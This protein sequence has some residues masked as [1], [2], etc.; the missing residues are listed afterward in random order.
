[1]KVRSNRIHAVEPDE[2]GYYER[3]YISLVARVYNKPYQWQWS[4]RNESAMKSPF[5]GMDP[6]LEAHWGDIHTSLMVYARNQLNTQLPDDLQA[7][8]EESL[9]VQEDDE[10]TRTV[11]ADVRVIEEPD[12]LLGD[13]GEATEVMTLAEPVLVTVIDEEQTQRQLEIV[14]SSDGG[15][16]VTAIEILSPANKLSADGQLAYI[17][18]QREY[19]DAR[20]NLI[21]IDLIRA[22]SFVLAVPEDRLPD[23]CRTNHLVCARR[24]GTPNVAELYPISLRRVLPNVR[25]P[26]RPKDQDV[27]LQLQP[28]LD[29]CYRDG[30]YDRL[31]Y[32]LDPTPRL[33]ESDAR[34]LDEVLRSKG[35]R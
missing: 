26:L 4:F 19:L 29:A 6:Y 21:E 18:K 27:V 25:I 28:L 3:P 1:M 33:S 14:D 10:R 2:S 16:V 15:R 5:P 13:R 12:A 23:S 7:R 8:V 30:R 20:V 32:R 34:W 31:N 17:R 9:A 35:L 24:A 22:G 11:Y